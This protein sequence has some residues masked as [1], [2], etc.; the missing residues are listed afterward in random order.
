MTLI[1]AHCHLGNLPKYVIHEGLLPV[2]VGY[3]HSSNQ[4]AVE[5]AK[6]HNVPFVL[7]IAPQ[8]AIKED[9]SKLGEWIDF[10]R[11]SGPNA[12]GEVGLDYHWAQNEQDIA[13]EKTV[14][15]RMIALAEEMGLPL[16]IHARDATPDVLDSLQLRNFR[17]G[18]MLHFFSGTLHD[19]KRAARMGG[20][21]S[22]PPVRSAGRTAAIGA[23]PLERLLVETDAPY[24]G[25]TPDAAMDSVAYI[26]EVKKVDRETVIEQTAKNARAFFKIR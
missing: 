13:K 15:E 2:T 24:V 1:D 26:A 11:K 17:N 22:I 5:A 12:I 8:T 3:S 10:I 7:G 18:F 6:K 19:A 16:V 20:Y 9:L 25:R 23:L 4:K 14:F 21:V